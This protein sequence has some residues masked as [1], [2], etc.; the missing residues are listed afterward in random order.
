MNVAR[1][2]GRGGYRE[3]LQVGLPL[4]A[5]M[6]STTVMQFTDRVF[7]GR[8]S[9]DALAASLS[10]SVVNFVFTAFF[11]GVATYVNVFIAQYTGAQRP[12][13]V[14][15]AL[16]QSIWFSVLAAV[17]MALL[18]LPAEWI[19]G[20]AGHSE[21]VQALEVP[22]YRILC[23]G[24]GFSVLAVALAS[25]YSGRGM[26]RP[27]AV[28]NMIGAVLNIP[29]D[30]ALI[31]GAWGFPR[32]GIEGAGYATVFA[33][34]VTALLFGAAVF[35]RRHEERYK[36][37]SNWRPD[38]VL[39]RR[40]L[41]FG[42][43]SGVQFF[44]DIF[45]FTVFI[46]VVGRMGDVELA[47]TNLVFSLN[48]FTFM[49]MVGLHIATETLMGQAI[50]AGRP[51]EGARA[52]TSAMH[53]CLAWALLLGAVFVLFPG[54]LVELFRPADQT[55]E[56]F[57]PIMEMGRVLLIFVAGYSFFDGM[58]I[59]QFGAL[60]GA[61]DTRFVML[62]ILCCSVVLLIVPVVYVVEVAQ[63]GLYVAWACVAA[64]LAGLSLITRLRFAG[65]KWRGMSVIEH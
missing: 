37:L 25:F 4:V 17:G 24:S 14:G 41:R 57:E 42:V 29:L 32:L 47:A 52:T 46:L 58:A 28:I 20:L 2:E 55:P 48:H 18:A 40:L 39:F 36:V 60:K 21:S 19:F 49:P 26:T 43:P 64:Y 31:N 50:G 38:P 63:A 51:D 9:L 10:S 7:L 13:R 1:W 45:G 5:S 61:G 35:V 65:G 23:F 30:Y 22:Y 16:W 12:E 56:Q 27:V 54:P 53:L 6:A 34:G 15:A 59:V 3:V 11:I 44:L 62:T 8:Y 33:W